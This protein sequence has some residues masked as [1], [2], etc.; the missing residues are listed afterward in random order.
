M[1][2]LWTAISLKRENQ[3][4]KTNS[5]LLAFSKIQI[6]TAVRHHYTAM[7]MTKIVTT[8]KVDK[9]AEEEPDCP[10]FIDRNI[11]QPFW[12]T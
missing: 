5:A 8:P 11:K 6:K 10:S 3:H 4:I 1:Q 7:R 12:K 2:K 9:N